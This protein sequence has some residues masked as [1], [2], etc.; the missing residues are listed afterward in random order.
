MRSILS[1]R[2]A[3]SYKGELC[4][5]HDGTR[6]EG[7]LV[8]GS[9]VVLRL[10]VRD[11]SAASFRYLESLS[12]KVALGET[13][14]SKYSIGRNSVTR[15][16]LKAHPGSALAPAGV[17][18]VACRRPRRGRKIESVRAYAKAAFAKTRMRGRASLA[19]VLARLAFLVP[20][21]EKPPA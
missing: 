8:F 3:A 4:G 5:A 15:N 11:R 14:A 20:H 19:G 1:S 16:K 21:V 7:V 10:A 9:D 12:S 2:F 13:L 17:L 6:A 18:L